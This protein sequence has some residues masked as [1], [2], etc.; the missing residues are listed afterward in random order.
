MVGQVERRERERVDLLR[1]EMEANRLK[2]EFLAALSHELR[3]PFNAI[4]GWLQILRAAPPSPQT[5]SARSAAS[6]GTPARRCA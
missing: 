2:D 1:R 3:T 6:I 4:L 5:A